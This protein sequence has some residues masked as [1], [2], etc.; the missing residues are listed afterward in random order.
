MKRYIKNYRKEIEVAKHNKSQGSDNICD[1]PF[2]VDIQTMDKINPS[3]SLITLHHILFYLSL[4]RELGVGG[5]QNLFNY[6]QVLLL[7]RM[8][9]TSINLGCK[10]R[11]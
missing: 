6:L 4:R 5:P 1:R 2:V 3:I 8:I 9:R 7:I 10:H 11:S